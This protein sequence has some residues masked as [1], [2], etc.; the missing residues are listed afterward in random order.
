[1]QFIDYIIIQIDTDVSEL[2]NIPKLDE[3][4]EFTPQ[5]LIEKVIE[6]FRAVIGDDFYSKYQQKIIFA[7][8]VL[9][10]ECWLLPLYYTDKKKKSKFKGCLRDLNLQLAKKHKFTIDAKA[11][12]PEYYRV[13][14]EQ[15]RKPK[16][17]MK[18]YAENP[19]L[20]IFI[21]EIKSRDIK[22]GDEEDW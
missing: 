19:S 15:Y 17:L 13:I 20:K 2:Y 14:S 7:I 1:M 21:E 16:V 18:H 3:N 22:I 6:K 5:E 4:G 11:K 8:S 12:N 10:L 9:S